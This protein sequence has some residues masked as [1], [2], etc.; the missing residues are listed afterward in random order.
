MADPIRLKPLNRQLSRLAVLDFPDT[1]AQSVSE[2]GVFLT[3]V[4]V[5]DLALVNFP[6]STGL[7]TF[8]CSFDARIA[9]DGEVRVR[10]NNYSSGN[11]DPV[12]ATFRV[13]VIPYSQ[14]EN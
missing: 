5:G 4:R 11:L 10:F 1:P 13:V 7:G 2:I 8:G 9:T 6:D 3:G 14:T 12:E